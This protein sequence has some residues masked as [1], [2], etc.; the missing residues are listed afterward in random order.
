M[1]PLLRPLDPPLRIPGILITVWC[2]VTVFPQA[3]HHLCPCLNNKTP[4]TSNRFPHPPKLPWTLVLRAKPVNA[5]CAMNDRWML[6][7]TPVD[8]CACASNVL[9]LL[10]IIK[11]LYALYADKK[12]KMWLK[13][14]KHDACEESFKSEICMILNDLFVSDALEFC[15]FVRVSVV[16]AAL[17]NTCIN[18]HKLE[19]INLFSRL[20]IPLPVWNGKFRSV[21]RLLSP[22]LISS[23]H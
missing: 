3:S 17:T 6:C 8:T 13:Y 1:C 22:L 2:G 23:F 7:Y 20:A 21:L 15:F 16:L 12:L 19:N 14:T 4:H 9:L 18:A 10:K 5:L 11:V